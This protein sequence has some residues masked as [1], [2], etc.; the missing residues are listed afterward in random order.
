MQP[1]TLLLAN[2]KGGV[3]KTTLACALASVALERNFAVSC[4]DMD[5]QKSLLNWAKRKNIPC[6]ADR[7]FDID[8][9]LRK[10]K[11]DLLI[12][13][14]QATLRGDNLERAVK[15]A[16]A[17]IVPVTN[18]RVDIEASARFLRRMSKIKALRKGKALLFPVLNKVTVYSAAEQ[19]I[20][21]AEQAL[22]FPIAA[23]FPA[24]KSF[25]DLVSLGRSVKSWRYAQRALVEHNLWRLLVLAGLEDKTQDIIDNAA[26]NE[27]DNEADSEA[28]SEANHK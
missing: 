28:D 7:K 4:Y 11:P 26:H 22:S 23:A 15:L 21:K 6:T 3:G 19:E 2:A 24:T 14:S 1:R 16:D 17:I 8:R 13:D 18:S 9:L 25:D 10:E 5:R 12:I 20:Q 27:A